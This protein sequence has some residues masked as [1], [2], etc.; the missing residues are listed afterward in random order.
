MDSKTS[1]IPEDDLG[2]KER[3]RSRAAPAFYISRDDPKQRSSRVLI[4]KD[5]RLPESRR[6]SLESKRSG[7]DV[8]PPLERSRNKDGVAAGTYEPGSS[9]KQRAS[10]DDV[11]SGND[12]QRPILRQ[13]T[14]RTTRTAS[15][16]EAEPLNGQYSERP[17]KVYRDEFLSF[18]EEDFR[19]SPRSPRTRVEGEDGMKRSMREIASSDEEGRISRTADR[20][21]KREA[22]E[23]HLAH[24]SCQ[25]SVV[26]IDGDDDREH[27]ISKRRPSTERFFSDSEE[28]GAR[29]TTDERSRRQSFESV[30]A[31]DYRKSGKQSTGTIDEGGERERSLSRRTWVSTKRAPSQ[32]DDIEDKRPAEQL[33]KRYSDDAPPVDGSHR[34]N[35]RLSIATTDEEDRRE[36]SSFEQRLPSMERPFSK[37]EEA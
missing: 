17:I 7:D 21:S 22:Y 34:K 35:R 28:A 8:N 9:R 36:R 29:Q 32:R 33:S 26:A 30:P 25:F 19:N 1:N 24:K 16:T 20:H 37:S 10:V 31:I 27:R 4:H 3:T 15:A 5:R 18:D 23:E 13:T 11:Y 2:A 12:M 6:G 14:A